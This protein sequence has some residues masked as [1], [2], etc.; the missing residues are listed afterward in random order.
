[1]DSPSTTADIASE[2]AT[3]DSSSAYSAPEA[4]RQSVRKTLANLKA[5]TIS[6]Y[7]SMSYIIADAVGFIKRNPQP[8]AALRWP[9]TLSLLPS[10]STTEGRGKAARRS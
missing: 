3:K 4:P 8:P 1:M 5:F 2:A 10:A 6:L 9:E 7:F